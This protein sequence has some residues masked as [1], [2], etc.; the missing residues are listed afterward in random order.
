[1]K[2]IKLAFI[3]IIFFAVLV[4]LISLF[5]PSNVRISK[6][7]DISA[8]KDSI[9]SRLGD[10]GKWKS[11]YPGADTLPPITMMGK[12][13]AIRLNEKGAMLRVTGRSDSTI[14]ITA[15]GPG[16][17]E[18]H[19]GWNI[20]PAATPNRHT[21]QWYM[22]FKLRWYPWEKFSSVMFEKR[23]GPVLEQGLEKLRAVLER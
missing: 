23:Y 8:P 11:W 15:T 1:M 7:L 18:M 4:T 21:V 2:Y 22:D 19:S 17:K 14:A 9:I 20:Y 16:V 13:I 6:A 10:P 12:T 3:S 5:F